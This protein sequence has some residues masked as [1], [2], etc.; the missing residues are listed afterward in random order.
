MTEGLLAFPACA[1]FRDFDDDADGGEFGANRVRCF[2]IPRLSR[3]FHLFYF[4]FDIGVRNGSFEQSRADL[5]TLGLRPLDDALDFGRVV[6]F[7]YGEEFVKLPQR[8]EER[9]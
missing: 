6:V 5:T 8:G 4:L 2:E 3:P 7:E 9:W 1:V